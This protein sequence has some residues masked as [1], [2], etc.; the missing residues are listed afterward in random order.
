MGSLWGQGQR[1]SGRGRIRTSDL[2]GY[3]EDRVC[4]RILLDE[5]D[6]LACRDDEQH[7]L[8]AFRLALYFV[9]HGQLAVR[10]APDYK[11]LAFPRDLFFDGQRRVAKLLTE[12]LRRLLL[13]LANFPTVDD[14]V[15]LLGG[16]VNAKRAKT[17]VSEVHGGLFPVRKRFRRFSLR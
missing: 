4:R 7:Y 16:F 8:A 10:P 11:A 12:S 1:V 15:V 13:A 3:V 6:G 17:K 5:L 9:H 14:E 2:T